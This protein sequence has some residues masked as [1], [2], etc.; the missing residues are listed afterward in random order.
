[1]AKNSLPVRQPGASGA[2]KPELV[3]NPPPK[4]VFVPAKKG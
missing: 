2:G 4:V 3:P 1:M